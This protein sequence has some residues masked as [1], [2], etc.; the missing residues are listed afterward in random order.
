MT[1]AR[2]EALK[3]MEAEAK[4]LKA[5]AVVCVRFTTSQT[6]AGAA[7][8]LVFGTAVKLKK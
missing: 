5:D 6:T 8:F 3:R 7:E 2:E 1:E 4:K